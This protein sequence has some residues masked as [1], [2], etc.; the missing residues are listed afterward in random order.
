MIASLVPFRSYKM[1]PSDFE[2]KYGLR[3][4]GPGWYKLPTELEGL[5]PVNVW[6]SGATWMLALPE[7]RKG[8]TELNEDF[9]ALEQI[10]FY[11]FTKD[12]RPTFDLL[13]HAPKR[14]FGKR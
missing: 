9:S 1:T 11:L 13:L 5:G 14:E 2:S 8:G 7:G 10:R 4:A 6:M 3:F 12:P